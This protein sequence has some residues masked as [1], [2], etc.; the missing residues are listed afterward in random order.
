MWLP[1]ARKDD[2]VDRRAS[3]PSTRGGFS[4]L[5]P[6][7]GDGLDLPMNA[8]ELLFVRQSNGSESE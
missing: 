2:P 6:T 3:A 5:K 8:V 1:H 4:P 7:D